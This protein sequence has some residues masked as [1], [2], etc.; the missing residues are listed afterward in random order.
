M[1]PQ[2]LVPGSLCATVPCTELPAR[3]SESNALW[4]APGLLPEA[5]PSSS[6]PVPMAWPADA[7][8]GTA[9]CLPFDDTWVS[10]GNPPTL[11]YFISEGVHMLGLWHNCEVEPKQKA[12][13]KVP[14]DCKV[15]LF[16]VAARAALLSCRYPA[17]VIDTF[18]S[19]HPL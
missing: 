12:L 3:G 4:P 15:S 11:P 9:W 13:C 19:V 1:C 7:P 10:H 14:R 8:P 16:G 18:W 5:G 2:D 17:S 6:A